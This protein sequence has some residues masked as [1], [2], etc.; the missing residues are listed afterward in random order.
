MKIWIFQ[1]GEPLHS[2]KGALRPMRAMNL[3]NAL[4]AAG[5]NVTLWSS[6]FSHQER[7]HRTSGFQ[8]IKINDL[9]Q[10]HLIPSPGYKRNIGLGRLI[11]HA[12]LAMN[13]KNALS[14]K[15]DN[16]DVA[17]IGYPPIEF[18]Y[19]AQRWLKERN[20]HTILDVKDL[21]PEI[22]ISSL[23]LCIQDFG[24]V[25]LFP[26]FYMAKKVITNA[27]AVSS[28]SESF[29]EYIINYFGRSRSKLD[30]VIPFSSSRVQVTDAQIDIAKVWWKN[31]GIKTNVKY[32][33]C[34]VGNIS[35]N[36]DLGPIKEAAKYFKKN[37]D[38]V[39]FFIC[40]NGISYKERKDE[41]RNITNVK[42]TGRIDHAQAIVL[43]SMSNAMLIPYKNSRDFQLSLP[44]KFIDSLFYGLPVFSPLEGEVAKMIKLYNIGI[45]YGEVFGNSL[46]DAINT[47][48]KDNNLQEQMIEN[49]RDVFL[50]KFTYKIVYENLANHL[51]S[52]K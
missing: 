12:V 22:F 23:P 36:V 25:L 20:V 39:E 43:S 51:I 35:P 45:S 10:I 30:I 4:V 9:L 44:N 3:A 50:K 18:S 1:T 46:I 11:D 8:T 31:F 41:F 5:H 48:L 37:C 15:Q 13:L 26:Y 16:P 38:E 27:T 21:W 33:L 17:F 14:K 6:A 19:V 47:V 42:F 7:R 40:G 29:L 24:K 32:R 34:Y 52:I 2:D 49:A 28:M